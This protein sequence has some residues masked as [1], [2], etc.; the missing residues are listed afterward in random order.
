[1][2]PA[3]PAVGLLLA[4]GRG[5]RFDPSG[6]RDKLLADAGGL[7]VATRTAGALVRACDLCIAVVRPA[8]DRVADAVR[9]GGIADV[10]TCADAAQGMGHSLAY[11]ARLAARHAPRRLVVMLADL[12]WV[13][14]ATIRRLIEAADELGAERPGLIVVPSFGGRQGHPVVFGP[15]HLDALQE[16]SGDR[17]A[18]SLLRE[19]PVERIAVDDEGVVRDVDTPADLN[20]DEP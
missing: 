1:M 17:G 3:G 7:A 2:N 14:P 9:A 6:T 16:C 20:P 5:A 4:A 12:P 10:A 19:Y 8:A 15:E 18:A 13:E 11:G